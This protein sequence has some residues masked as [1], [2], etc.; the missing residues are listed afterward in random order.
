MLCR[1][2]ANLAE[3]RSQCFQAPCFH[4]AHAHVEIAAAAASAAA[5]LTAAE[6][7]SPPPQVCYISEDYWRR[8]NRR[9]DVKVSLCL[10]ASKVF[11]IPRYAETIEVGVFN[12]QVVCVPG[13]LGD[14]HCLVAL[15]TMQMLSSSWGVCLMAHVPS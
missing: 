5:S 3:L 15:P 6:T 7:V 10:P 12:R 14:R 13:P 9:P 8:H 1:K 11:G 4:G 2:Q